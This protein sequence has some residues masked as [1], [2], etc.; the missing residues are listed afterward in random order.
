M[1][2]KLKKIIVFCVRTAKRRALAILFSIRCSMA[3]DKSCNRVFSCACKRRIGALSANGCDHNDTVYITGGCADDIN[4]E[5]FQINAL[6][7]R[8]N[9]SG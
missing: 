9:S 3:C 2:I 4:G 1:R 8:N 7:T 6:W 5:I